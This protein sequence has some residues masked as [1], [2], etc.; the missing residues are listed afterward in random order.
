MRVEPAGTH[1]TYCSSIHPGESWAA[2]RANLER[3]LPQVKAQVCPERPFGIGL[4]LSAQ[5]AAALAE[6]GALASFRAFLEAGDLYVFTLNGFPY[7]AFHGT[8]VKERVYLPDWTDPERLR[9]TN[10]LAELLSALLPADGSLAGSIS[11]VPGAFKANARTPQ[12]VQRIAEHILAHAAHLVRLR[13]SAGRTVALAL[14]PEPACLLETVDEAVDFFERRLFSPA[15]GAALARRTG[16]G[17]GEAESALRRHLGVCLD[18]CHAAVEFEDPER[19]VSRLR[20]AGIPVHKVQLSAG[21]RLTGVR[22]AHALLG[23]FDDGVYLHQVVGRDANGLQRHVDLPQALRSPAAAAAREW[24]VHFHVPLFLESLQDEGPAGAGAL[25]TTQPFVRALLAQ[26]RRAP[27]TSHLEVET[28]TWDVLPPRYRAECVVS[29]IA[30]EL[31]W[32][33]GQLRAVPS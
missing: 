31:R 20:A 10:R 2:V 6:P 24:R 12:R 15:A 1:L 13:E 4:R 32:V 19:L 27:F 33:L 16:L 30:R 11:T 7:G 29:A 18:L 17:R 25:T 26:H 28:Y 3:Y 14:E 22:R 8:R 21:L 5:A 23:P 9:Y